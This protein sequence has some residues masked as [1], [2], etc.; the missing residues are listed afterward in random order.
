MICI[1]VILP[2]RFQEA[3]VM[4]GVNQMKTMPLLSRQLVADRM[5]L[6]RPG[7]IA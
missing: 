2:L 7:M 1:R 3:Q 4:G 5:S 6:E